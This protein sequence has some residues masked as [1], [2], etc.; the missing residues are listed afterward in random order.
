MVD[1]ILEIISY[2]ETFF[3]QIVALSI[4]LGATFLVMYVMNA[5]LN[6][7]LKRISEKS[8]SLQTIY[9]VLRRLI[10]ATVVV[11]GVSITVFSVFPNLGTAVASIFVAAGFASIV[12]GMAAQSTLSNIISGI[13]ISLSQPFKINDAVTFKNDFCFVEDIRLTYTV[14]RTWD[15][16]RLMVPNSLMQSEVI[17][18]YTTVDPSVLVPIMITISYKSDADKAM[19]ILV[20]IAKK[21]PACFPTGDLPNA[22]IMDFD[23]TG[24]K[25]RLLSRAKDQPTAFSMSRDIMAAAKKEFDQNGIEFPSIRN[26]LI[27]DQDA[28]PPSRA[29]RRTKKDAAPSE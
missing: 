21:H 27:W 12:L 3:W 16:R 11:I 5:L 17:I 20:D 29:R 23:T 25:L 28:A 10:L 4:G 24:V 19:A 26:Y 9:V 2:F 22:V 8:P 18:N 1:I 6:R 7:R 13:T 15:N 14:L